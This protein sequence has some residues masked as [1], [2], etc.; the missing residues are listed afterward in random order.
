MKSQRDLGIDAVRGLA[1]VM[2][3]STHALR[4]FR[5]STLPDFA[6]WLFRIEP[7]TP[8]IF[9]LV[10]GWGLSQS[11]RRT[12][13]VSAW[14]RR[15]WKRSGLLFGISAAMFFVYSGPQWPES[16]VSTGVLG[17]LAWTIA[18]GTLIL[19]RTSL[20]IALLVATVAIRAVF[21]SKGIHMDGLN[22]GTFALLPNLP[23]FLA[24]LLGDRLLDRN[25]TYEAIAGT[26]GALVILFLSYR[27]GFRNLWEGWGIERSTQEY[28]VTVNHS[29]N[30]FAMVYDLLRGIPTRTIHA[31]FNTPTMALLPV[32][33]AMAGLCSQF[34]CMV[35]D[36]FPHRLSA[37]SSLGRHGLVYY[38][39]H[40]VALGAIAVFLPAS[41]ANWSWTWLIVTVLVAGLGIIL[42]HRFDSR[43]A[44]A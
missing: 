5:P 25:R 32:L 22:A 29:H 44:R 12:S 39:T 35:T 21:D 43:G 3:T 18:I 11:L 41:L 10:A 24:G 8:A 4:M 6:Q 9:F 30:G 31:R 33:V 40:F 19:P 38:L 16:I 13:D 37:L 27:V 1:M 34:F 36:R 28:L 23:I 26:A 14:R 7:V 2:M 20:A 42:M 15:Q 17:C